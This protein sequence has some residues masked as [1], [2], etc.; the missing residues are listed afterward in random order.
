MCCVLGEYPRGRYGNEGFD[1]KAFS[2]TG[3]LMSPW[4]LAQCPVGTGSL[5]SGHSGTALG[6]PVTFSD[7]ISSLRQCGSATGLS[8]GIVMKYSIGK[9]FVLIRTRIVIAA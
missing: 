7:H 6:N 1:L 2:W 8:S 4:I 9:Q 5:Q 3:T